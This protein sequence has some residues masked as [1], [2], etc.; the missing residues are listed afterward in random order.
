MTNIKICLEVFTATKLNK[1]FSGE[2]PRKKIYK[3]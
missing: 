2:Q 1:V 3:I